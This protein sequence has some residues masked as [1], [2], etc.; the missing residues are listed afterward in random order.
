M[1]L[2]GHSAGPPSSV[3]APVRDRVIGHNPCADT[4]LPKVVPA[5]VRILA[6]EEFDRLLAQIP[7]RHAAL[8]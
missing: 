4:E 3:R 2:Q 8:V 6:P 7:A 5:K 1:T